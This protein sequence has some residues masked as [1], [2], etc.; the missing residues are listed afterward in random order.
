MAMMENEDWSGMFLTLGAIDKAG[1]MW[2]A[3]K[4]V[5]TPRTDPGYQTHV[6]FSA[7]NADMQ[8]GRILAKLRDLGQLDETL[9]V[10]TADHGATH[11]ANFYGQKTAG[12]STN[13]WYY[14]E[15]ANDGNGL[16][17]AGPYNTPS[18][19]LAPLIATGNVQFSYQSTGIETWL[20]DN[21][22][23]KKLEAANIMTTL[24]GVIASYYRDGN[25]FQLVDTNPMTNAER[26]W[27]RAHGQQIINT[28]AA[29]N[30][31]D[32]VGLLHDDTS[33]GAYGDHGGATQEVQ[34]VPMVFWSPGLQFHNTTGATFHTHDVLPTIL[35]TMGIPLVH[36]VDGRA[37]NL[38]N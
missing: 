2:G 24:P 7:K 31:P 18:P 29:A 30:G 34:E 21:S 6:K 32:V 14:G 20:T 37:R 16:A 36:P 26:R 3:N 9:V 35:R 38:D 33:Y 28:M 4:D 13:N 19:A 12:A 23:A 5:Q 8:L 22:L 11:G 15:A 10:L 25:R 1:H 27:W 17:V